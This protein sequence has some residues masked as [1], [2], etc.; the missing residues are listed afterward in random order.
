MKS[1]IIEILFEVI[2]KITVPSK[3]LL[4]PQA[5]E[6]MYGSIG[7]PVAKQLCRLAAELE[8]EAEDKKI[9]FCLDSSASPEV[10]ELWFRRMIVRLMA[11]YDMR[12]QTGY[13]PAGELFLRKNFMVVTKL[14]N[15][16]GV[17]SA[18]VH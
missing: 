1:S 9:P 2:R 8:Q 18:C 14:D 15:L 17:Q 4:P 13:W 5:D 3:E 12:N 7:S 11:E 16:T 6:L 10:V